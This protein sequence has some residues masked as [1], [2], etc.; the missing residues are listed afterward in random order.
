MDKRRLPIGMQAFRNIRNKECYYVDK[1]LHI[2]RLVD[3]GEYYFLSRPRRFGKSLLISTLKELFEGSEEL[4]RGLYIH[5]RWDWNT[6]HPVVRLSFDANYSE[7]G[8]LKSNIFSQLIAHEGEAGIEPPP[9]AS[10]APDRLQR[11]IRYLYR[12]TRQQVVIL[13]DE[14]DKPI[15]DALEN[16]ELAQENRDYLRGFY[17][18]IKG[19]ADYIRFVFITGISMYSKVSLFSV[20]NNLYDLSLD[21]EYATLCGYTDDD[22]ETVFAPELANVTDDDRENIRHWYNGYHWR[23]KEKVYNPFDILLYFQRREFLPWWY[24]TGTPSFLYHRMASGEISTREFSNL[25][26]HY[27]DLSRFDLEQVNLYALLFQ[28]GYLTITG[29]QDRDGDPFYTLDYPN[30]E[31]RLSLNRQL[32]TAVSGKSTAQVLNQ[33]ATLTRL[34]AANDFTALEEEL[35]SLFSCIPHQWYDGNEIARYEGHYASVLFS[36]FSALNLAIRVEDASRH[37]RADLVVMYQDQVFIF[38]LKVVD[39]TDVE[40][41]A[42]QAMAQMRERGYADK[43]RRQGKRIHLLAAV[44]SR[45]SRN[46]GMLRTQQA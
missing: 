5:E 28:C 41:K 40:A 33:G 1:T 20:L 8:N 36:S 10:T 7:S 26:M 4:F 42:Q 43:Y 21:P 45:D 13:I 23:G 39:G 9:E 17:G 37:G 16:K 2:E 34:L 27:S 12:D 6:K 18:M 22:L 31:V 35:R 14:Y 32:L 3:E 38:E 46:L 30:R 44:F 25:E 15:L 11:L 29:E 24:E 19:C